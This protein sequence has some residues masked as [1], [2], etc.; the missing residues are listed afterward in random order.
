[1]IKKV[2]YLNPEL[3]AHSEISL[4]IYDEDDLSSHY[5][6]SEVASVDHTYGSPSPTKTREAE[7]PMKYHGASQDTIM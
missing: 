4:S 7:S 2:D 5:N 6:S 1:M 3:D